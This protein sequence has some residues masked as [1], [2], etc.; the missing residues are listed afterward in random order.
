MPLSSG[1]RI[2]GEAFGP[3]G[4]SLLK[5]GMSNRS[6]GAPAFEYGEMGFVPSPGARQV[7]DLF[8]RQRQVPLTIK[9]AAS[10]EAF[11]GQGMW[12]TGGGY[13]RADDRGTVVVDPIAAQTSTVAHEAA[14]ATFP[15]AALEASVERKQGIDPLGI[16]RAQ[17]ARLRYIHNTMASP[18]V[19]EEA[20]AQGV[21]NAV[22]DKVGT[23]F[24]TLGWPD[25]RAYPASYV[26][27]GLDAYADAEMGPMSPAENS[28]AKRIMRASG[29]YIDRMYG[30][31]YK[32]G[33]SLFQ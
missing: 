2:A 30:A 33:L 16:P 26:T 29:P 20:H 5:S 17:G 27:K 1:Q 19:G 15:T 3:E 21:A 28:E 18:V 25:A 23:P 22:M 6:I 24:D 12:G 13:V 4:L 8:N 14:H 7:L 11:N 32:R 10:V 31:G 9:P